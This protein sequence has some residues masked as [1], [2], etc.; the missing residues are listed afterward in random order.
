MS[1]NASMITDDDNKSFSH[2]EM[3]EGARQLGF[4]LEPRCVI[5]TQEGKQCM[6]NATK[7]LSGTEIPCCHR[8]I[9]AKESDV[10]PN[11]VPCRLIFPAEYE[12]KQGRDV[13]V[14]EPK[15]DMKRCHGKSAKAQARCQNA[16]IEGSDF[17]HSHIRCTERAYNEEE[18]V[19]YCGAKTVAGTP[20]K[21][22][23][24]AGKDMCSTHTTKSDT[25]TPSPTPSSTPII[26][27]GMCCAITSKKTQCSRKGTNDLGGQKYCAQHFGIMS[28]K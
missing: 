3:I 22:A 14:V 5:K 25:S 28:N 15:E 8:H 19:K 7:V 26:T 20:C 1:A 6:V 10:V 9:G 27:E 4:V 13:E 23:C 17:C 24:L 16:C 12:Q 21:N 18:M 2:E 11:A